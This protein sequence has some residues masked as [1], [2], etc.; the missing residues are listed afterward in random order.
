M[1]CPSCLKEISDNIIARYLASKGGAKSKRHI[2][3]FAQK[4]MQAGR[5]NKKII[6]LEDGTSEDL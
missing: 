3:T 4:K 5:K 6:D 2:S 1:K